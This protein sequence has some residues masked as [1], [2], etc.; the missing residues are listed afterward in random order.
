MVLENHHVLFFFV[1]RTSNEPHPAG[2]GFVF[3]IEIMADLTVVED[4][5]RKNIRMV[6]VVPS[7]CVVID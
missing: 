6:F 3:A 1:P 7:L 4:L 5:R 2:V